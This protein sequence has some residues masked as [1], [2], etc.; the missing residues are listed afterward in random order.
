[1]TIDR[2]ANDFAHL[3]LTGKPVQAAEKY[4]ADDIVRIEPARLPEG[5][6]RQATGYAA[7]LAKLLEWI[8]ES[9]AAELVIDGPFVTG[10]VF[11]LFLDMEI[12]VPGT[13]SREPF[14]EIAIFTVRDQKI[15][16]E[17][18]FYG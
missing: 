1:M 8:E 16:E 14:S 18:Y 13:G 5:K 11:A 12:A 3:L 9:D 6:P 4:W 7:S 17:R 15:I 2:L 10:N